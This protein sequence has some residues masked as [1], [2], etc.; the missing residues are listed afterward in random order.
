MVL[1]NV[2]GPALTMR[3]TVDALEH[4]G[5]HVVV[6]AS[7][8]GHVN[9]PGSLY[10]ATKHAAVAL[11]ESA[12]LEFHARGIRVT[13]ISPGNVNTPFFDNRPQI[14]LDPDDVARAVMFAVTQPP[15]VGINEIVMRH[16]DQTI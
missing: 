16:R 8:A 7:I 13:A 15:E 1:T 10:S 11:T 3:A 14:A 5:G 12:R 9:L 2:L 4:T 6:T